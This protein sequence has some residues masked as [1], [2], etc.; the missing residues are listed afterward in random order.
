MAFYGPLNS[1]QA[2]AAA[3]TN[4]TRTL[5]GDSGWVTHL[6]VSFTTAV[7]GPVHCNFNAIHAYEAGAVNL[8]GRF[9]L[10]SS[11]ASYEMQLVKQGFSSNMSFGAH[12][13]FGTFNDV[14]AGSHSV[15]LQLRNYVA[16]TTGIMCYFNHNNH[17]N[18]VLQVRY[19]G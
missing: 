4:S 6:S 18:D 15:A 10:D 2:L 3:T 17:A 19:R 8:L 13:A 12:T 9:L 16:G 14:S 7:I 1:N 5:N 11:S